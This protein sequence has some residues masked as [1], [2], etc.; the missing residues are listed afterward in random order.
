MSWLALKLQSVS[1]KSHP[2]IIITYDFAYL[3]NGLFGLL[4]HPATCCIRP[5]VKRLFRHLFRNI[6]IQIATWNLYVTAEPVRGQLF[7]LSSWVSAHSQLGFHWLSYL[8]HGKLGRKTQTMV[9]SELFYIYIKL[10]FAKNVQHTKNIFCRKIISFVLLNFTQ[11][12][13]NKKPTWS[14]I[15]HSANCSC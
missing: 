5:K 12:R 4:P 8:P 10:C 13:V 14:T 3:I 1:L 15:S 6:L 11:M 9:Y 7:C 2:L